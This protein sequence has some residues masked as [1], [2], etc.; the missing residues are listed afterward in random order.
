M[1]YLSFNPHHN[2]MRCYYYPY[3]TDEERHSEGLSD[4]PKAGPLPLCF[5]NSPM[6]QAGQDH[7]H[8]FMDEIAEA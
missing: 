8:H 1:H 5:Q 6:K 7:D 2:L 4:L 3:F